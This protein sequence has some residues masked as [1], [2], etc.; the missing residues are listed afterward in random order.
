MSLLYIKLLLLLFSITVASNDTKEYMFVLLTMKF[1]FITL[2]TY[3]GAKNMALDE[4]IMEQV[5][6]GNELP[7]I[8]LY[9]WLPS[10]VTIGYFQ[11]LKQE[12]AEDECEK[13]G[14][15]IVRRQTGGGAVY[16]DEEITYSIIAPEEL[17][18]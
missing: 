16:H 14:V 12:V 4:A 6:K 5:R 13:K 7:T 18:A 17:L 8:R 9:K 10:C 11:G 2:Q 3:S 1:R 15:E